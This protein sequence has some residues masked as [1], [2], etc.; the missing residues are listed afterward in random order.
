MPFLHRSARLPARPRSAAPARR[1][2]ASCFLHAWL[3]RAVSCCRMHARADYF[4]LVEGVD[5]EG[6]RR[7]ACA[8]RRIEH[9]TLQ[10]RLPMVPTT[11]TDTAVHSKGGIG[12]SRRK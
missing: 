2:A 8:E 7:T 6:V 5:L 1:N 9:L 4:R 10:V 12:L 3:V 11:Q